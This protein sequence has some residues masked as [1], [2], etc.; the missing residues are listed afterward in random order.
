WSLYYVKGQYVA[1]ND[2]ML[3]RTREDL[4][5]YNYASY[6]VS[7]DLKK[8]TR[9]KLVP[10]FKAD[11]KNGMVNCFEIAQ[12]TE[13]GL[14]IRESTPYW[15]AYEEGLALPRM[16]LLYTTDF[17]K[18]KKV[19]TLNSTFVRS[20]KTGGAAIESVAMLDG[21]AAGQ[22]I[23]MVYPLETVVSKDGY[24]TNKSSQVCLYRSE[25]FNNYKK[26]AEFKGEWDYWRWTSDNNW[27]RVWLYVQGTKKNYVYITN[28]F[29]GTYKKY[30]TTLQA[31]KFYDR[32]EK[33]SWI[34]EIYG[35]KYILA[36]K[37]GGKTMY[38]IKNGLK[39]MTGIQ[40]VGSNLLVMTDGGYD[41][42]IP[43]ST[44]QKAAK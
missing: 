26:A 13:Q 32:T 21:N 16:Q 24:L 20:G 2:F 38:Q 36:S 15:F 25:G 6:Y 1:A 33:D 7:K 31:S 12:A 14:V 18:Y 35:G 28:S 39:N 3:L 17:S 44:L 30:S 27:K 4:S 41:Y 5:E 37:D 11:K 8:W 10:T 9:K 42:Y 40:V 29:N 19:S 43:I 23:A 22:S 34:Y